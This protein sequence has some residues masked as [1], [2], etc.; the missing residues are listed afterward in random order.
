MA[1][2]V[3][4]RRTAPSRAPLTAPANPIATSREQVF[5]RLQRDAGNEAVCQLLATKPRK[6]KK[7]RQPKSEFNDVAD[8]LN[9][10]Q[11]LATAATTKGARAVYGPKL[12]A[13]L[14]DE[15]RATLERVRRV[16]IKSQGSP[17]A[18]KAAAAEWP[19]L[20]AKLLAGVERGRKLGMN[21]EHLTTAID[22]IES[23]GVHYV[24]AKRNRAGADVKAS[25]GTVFIDG[26]RQLVNVVMVRPYDLTSGVVWTNIDQINT[27]QREALQAVKFGP[28]LS[29]RHRDLLDSLRKALVL[30]R[31]R[32]S[33]K[34]ALAI[35]KAIG[36]DVLTTFEKADDGQLG[37]T[38][39]T[40]VDIGQKL[41]HGGAYSEAHNKALEKVDLKDAK[42]AIVIDNLKVL[43]RDL[44]VAKDLADKSIAISAQTPMNAFFKKAGIGDELGNA[45]WDLAKNPGE[46][47]GKFE[48]LKKRGLLG[49]T[50][51]I[52][53]LGEK[54]LAL[55]NAAYTVGLTV[56]RDVAQRQSNVA[57][58]KGAAELVAK[59][60]RVGNW[61]AHHMEVLDK[62]GK[63]AG[64]IAIGVSAIKVIDA[65]A[66]GNWT[67]AFQEASST[68]IGVG[69]TAAMKVGG[70]AGGGLFATIGIVVAAEMEGIAGAA[71]MIRYAKEANL[72]EAALDFIHVCEAAAAIEAKSLIADARI[73]DDPDLADQREAIQKRL[74]GHRE[75]WQRHVA[76]MRALY[77][78]DRVN[79]LG[80]QPGLR[81]ALGAAAIGTLFSPPAATWEGL[82]NQIRTVFAGANAMSAHVVKQYPKK[83]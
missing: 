72:R 6:P 2:R 36:S 1:H 34:Q 9:G 23:V 42:E 54:M 70:L 58:A 20:A 74:I 39:A 15:H 27:Q 10:F 62:V 46:I 30:A 33:A 73:L 19:S 66:Q 13:D 37:E 82:G 35:W 79:A 32:G 71:A 18:R 64:V 25:S 45:I 50:V 22:N 59:W 63:V 75:W 60:E 31:T 76:E 83:A 53:D 51:T 40:L 56:I 5:L 24:K 65:I 38:R 3:A 17:A 8:F 4:D 81:R 26:V 67:A 49:K 14:S 11:E 77:L 47:A 7:P 61:V 16:L 48:D 55:R 43:A 69:A 12:G 57:L 80:G 68:A 28:G 52:V 44:I 41:I 29:V 78:N 21:A